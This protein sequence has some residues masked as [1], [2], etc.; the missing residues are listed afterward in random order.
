MSDH[1]LLLETGDR[2]LLETGDRLLLDPTTTLGDLT[3]LPSYPDRVPHVVTTRESTWATS[4]AV[5]VPVTI[6]IPA[7]LDAQ[8]WLP[9]Y[10]SRV[11]HSRVSRAQQGSML[12]ALAVAATN[13]VSWLPAYPVTVPARRLSTAARAQAFVAPSPDAQVVAQQLG[14]LAR[15]PLR[16]PRHPPP[17]PAGAFWTIPPQVPAT[18]VFCVDLGLDR[19]MTTDLISESVSGPALLSEGLG[20]TGLIAETLCTA[21]GGSGDGDQRIRWVQPGWVQE[22]WIQ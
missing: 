11:P 5:S 8:M 20:S 22:D 3:F 12:A 21:I 4:A 16:T 9:I 2:L 19:A 7:I 10:P 15:Y 18:G 17:T 6:P 13:P 14:W 1:S